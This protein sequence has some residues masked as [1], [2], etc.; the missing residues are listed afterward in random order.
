MRA[1]I[2]VLSC[3]GLALNG[4]AADDQVFHFFVSSDGSLARGVGKIPFW[5]KL[6]IV[7]NTAV[8]LES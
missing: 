2:I 1:V 5:V 7:I 4:P 8:H 6:G 3:N